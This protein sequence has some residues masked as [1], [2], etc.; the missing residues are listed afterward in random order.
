MDITL[1]SLAK[2]YIGIHEIEG[3]KDNPWIMAW[4]RLDN[5]WPS[6][7]EIA[8]CSA[9]VCA[10]AWVLDLPRPEAKYALRARRWLEIGT[11][12]DLEMAQARFDVV[13]LKRGLGDQGS[14]ILD[15]PGHVGI[16]VDQDDE[17]VTIL[18]GNQGNRVSMASY[19]IERLLGV[20]RLHDEMHV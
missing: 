19:P 12:I 10:Q 16:Y 2:H 6:H 4:L 18:G 8:W 17:N 9:F 1:Y 20:R 15:A 13:I 14:N 7:D 11:P 3:D 5:A